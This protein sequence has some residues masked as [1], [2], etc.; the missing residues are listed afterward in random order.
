M[1]INEAYLYKYMPEAERCLLS[2][3]PPDE[4]LQH[5]FSRRFERKMRALIKYERRTPWERK[6][7]RNLKLGFAIAAVV[8]LVVFGSAMSVKAY[9]FRVVEF[10]VQIF[11]ELTSYSVKEEKPEG[12]K[13]VPVEPSYVP[14]GY[15]VTLNVTSYSE[16]FI[17]YENAQGEEIHYNQA[18]ASSGVRLWDTEVSVTDEL[19]IGKQKVSVVETDKNRALYWKDKEY[20]YSILGPRTL[21]LD[22][23]LKM[24]RSVMK[25]VE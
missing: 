6:F 23:L 1:I 8:L 19:T 16:H 11:E 2:L 14:E 17:W 25:K 13:M 10:F 24:A 9:R 18:T 7:Y 12:V 15:V 22:E 3:I 5:K 20:V 4:E 21:E